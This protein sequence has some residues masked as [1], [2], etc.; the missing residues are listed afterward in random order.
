MAG[1]NKEYKPLQNV[2]ITLSELVKSS[3]MTLREVQRKLDKENRKVNDETINLY[4]VCS[5]ANGNPSQLSVVVRLDKFISN[6]LQTLGYDEC[7]L[8]EKNLGRLQNAPQ[9][10]DQQRYPKEI[11]EFLR[12]SVSD[13]YVRYAYKM[14]LRDKLTEELEEIK[15]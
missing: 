11:K 4:N 1:G 5:V 14:Y 7:D 6:I 2:M 9:S 3:G 13:K 10:D 15:P 12:S 8:T